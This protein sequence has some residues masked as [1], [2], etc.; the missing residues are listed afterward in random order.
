[1]NVCWR[2]GRE[3]YQV[4][5][6][7]ATVSTNC[8]AAAAWSPEAIRST[9]GAESFFRLPQAGRDSG[10]REQGEQRR[11]VPDKPR[12]RDA[13]QPARS[14]MDAPNEF[15]GYQRWREP[16]VSINAATS[17]TSSRTLPW[18]VGHWVFA[19][20]A[21]KSWAIFQPNAERRDPRDVVRHPETHAPGM[22]GISPVTVSS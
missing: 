14:V 1:M 21:P 18:P 3:F 16:Q 20:A 10:I 22:R 9:S 5:G 19:V 13:H 11:L 7:S 8:S 6:P 2:L 17:A 12:K 15:P 4:P